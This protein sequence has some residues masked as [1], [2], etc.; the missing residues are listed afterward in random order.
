[1]RRP[2]AVPMTPRGAIVTGVGRQ[3]GIAAAI[4]RAL[5][6]DGWNVLGSGWPAYDAAANWTVSAVDDINS[7]VADCRPGRLA[8]RQIDLESAM[9]AADLIE[10]GAARLPSLDARV[11]AHARSLA[12]GLADVTVEEFDRHVV[13]NARATLLLIAE[14][15]RRWRGAPG[16]GRIITFIS[17]P[18]L[19]GEI[20][21]AASKRAVEWLTLSAAAE[22]A[23]FLC[24]GRGGSVT[25]QVLHV[26]REWRAPFGVT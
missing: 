1:M 20:A 16:T 6:Q 10:A 23:A 9:G 8:L 26:D 13:V 17:N 14:F 24:S 25:G 19:E 22:L 21:Y 7:L 5:I 15:A 11:V 18:P 3:R 2:D 12:S 4:C